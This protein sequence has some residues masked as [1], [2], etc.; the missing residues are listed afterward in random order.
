VRRMQAIL[1][2]GHRVVTDADPIVI[3]QGLYA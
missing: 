3:R 1:G 2:I